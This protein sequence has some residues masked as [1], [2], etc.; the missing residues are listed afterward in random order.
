[1]LLSSAVNLIQ[2]EGSD[3]IANLASANGICGTFLYFVG[4]MAVVIFIGAWLT[5]AK[6]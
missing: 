2:D 4:I 3:V 5:S 6:D 1:M